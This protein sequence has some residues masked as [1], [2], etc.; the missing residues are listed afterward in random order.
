MRWYLKYYVIRK[1]REKLEQRLKEMRLEELKETFCDN[2]CKYLA[3]A[4]GKYSSPD[5][6]IDS[7]EDLEAF[8]E[9]CVLNKGV[10]N[11]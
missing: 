9:K 5:V 6:Q 2:Y 4:N 1:N 10:E 7:A 3:V 11:G 8:C